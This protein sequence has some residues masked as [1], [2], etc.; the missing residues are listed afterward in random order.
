M[1]KTQDLELLLK[2]ALLSSYIKNERPVSVLFSA[3]V[4]SGKTEILRKASQCKGV[5]FLND[6]TA[7]GIQK[8]H[9]DNIVNKVT[10]TLIMPD[11]ITPLSRAPD[12][13]ETFVT[14]LNGLI[15]EG[16]VEIQ[17]YAYSKKF[18]LPA[19]CNIITS[20][21]K[22]HLFDQRHQNHRRFSS[23]KKLYSPLFLHRLSTAD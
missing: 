17:T 4:E 23:I 20:I 22:E 5:A 11:L 7:F 13:V 8:E 6:A 19:R 16:L 18:T 3:K 1:I 21:A 2:L 12:T 10:R 15:E 9:L 14:F